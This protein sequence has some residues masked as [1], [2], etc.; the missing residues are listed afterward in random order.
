MAAS[1]IRLG[2]LHA[3]FTH[4]WEQRFAAAFNKDPEQRIPLTAAELAVV[5][6]FLKDNSVFGDPD[7]NGDLDDLARKLREQLAGDKVGEAELSAIMDD[8]MQHQMNGMH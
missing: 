5:R 4:Y 2:N 3:L 7:A 8:F 1:N 6:A